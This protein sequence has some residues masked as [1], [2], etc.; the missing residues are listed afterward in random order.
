M[1]RWR[2]AV[3]LRKGPSSHSGHLVSLLVY[4][5]SGLFH[6]YHAASMISRRNAARIHEPV[7]RV[8]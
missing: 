2:T 4:A 6:A 8:T 3:Q 1:Y 7:I 5:S